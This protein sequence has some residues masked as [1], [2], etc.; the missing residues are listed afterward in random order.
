MNTLHSRP[1][2]KT[3]FPN[4]FRTVLFALAGFAV[5]AMSQTVVS[6]L[7]VGDGTSDSRIRVE[8]NQP[9]ALGMKNTTDGIYAWMGA[10]TSG[11]YQFSDQN[12]FL[13]VLFKQGGNVG[14]GTGSPTMKLDVNG[15]TLIR[16]DITVNGN[17]A[18]KYQDV[19]EWVPVT[20][21]MSPGTVVVLNPRKVNEV[22]PAMR[23]YDT[24]VAGVVSETP[25][26]ILG[27]RGDSKAAIAT[28]GR[29]RVK[30]T[31][32]ERPIR[33]G[34]LLVTSDK[35]GMAMKSEPIKIG[36]HHLHQPGTIIGKALEP[37]AGG[38]GEI[39]VLL[40]LQ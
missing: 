8:S 31:A 13:L 36:D 14:I 39:L 27:E 12:G 28:F 35:D 5:P 19:A 17:I 37:L 25:G 2:T 6:N 33:I 1:M 32:S 23:S 20:E 11:D 7:R 4:L 16:G 30:A 21:T 22:M 10:T 29:V 18:A 34:D 3:G 15:N 9:Y 24:M 26:L 40:S 38:E